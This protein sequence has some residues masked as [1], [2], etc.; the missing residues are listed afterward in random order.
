GNLPKLS[1]ELI[2]FMLHGEDS[3]GSRFLGEE[4][5]FPVAIEAGQVPV[6]GPGVVFAGCCWGSLTVNELAS[7][8]M[9]GRAVTPRTPEESIALSFLQ[10]GFQAFVGC[11]GS[12]YSP[13]PDEN[14]WGGPM[15]L[16]FWQYLKGG[17]PPA[18]ALFRA[19]LDYLRDLPHGLTDAEDIALEHKILRQFT[20]LGLGW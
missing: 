19:K 1:G 10:A 17:E 5:L 15:H 11:T 8:T 18:N 20:C 4:S 3:D 12:H 13:P 7:R 2:Y 6:R 14:V 9:S 16:S